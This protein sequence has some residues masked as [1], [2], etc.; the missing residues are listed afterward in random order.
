MTIGNG[1]EATPRNRWSV[2]ITDAGLDE[3][4]RIAFK[5]CVEPHDL[6]ELS[7]LAHGG[8]DAAGLS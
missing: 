8:T 4:V 3:S 5:T 2:A 1:P 6:R 7:G